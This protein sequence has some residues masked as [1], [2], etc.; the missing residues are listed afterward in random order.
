MKHIFALHRGALTF[1]RRSFAAIERGPSC[2]VRASNA[3]ACTPPRAAARGALGH[4]SA[5]PCIALAAF[6][7]ALCACAST[8]STFAMT[9]VKQPVLDP[10]GLRLPV[11]VECQ[12][13]ASWS[14]DLV[15]AEC[16]GALVPGDVSLRA[17]WGLVYRGSVSLEEA[18]SSVQQ[19]SPAGHG[20]GA[21]PTQVKPSNY[22]KI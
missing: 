15:P 9:F 19:S 3:G 11:V 14:D 7:L 17:P 12:R 10:T 8:G 22:Y 20:A 18:A 13:K 16:P 5:P 1:G 4:R 2:P 21:D 6:A